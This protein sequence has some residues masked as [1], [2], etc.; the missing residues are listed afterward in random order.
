MLNVIAEVNIALSECS[1][2]VNEYFLSRVN[3]PPSDV[4]YNI[5]WE[6]DCFKDREKL[7]DLATKFVA[8]QA[9]KE[10][11]KYFNEEN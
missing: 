10:K 1:S 4:M 3:N 2:E 9:N 11:I 7:S 6:K 5:A 8:L